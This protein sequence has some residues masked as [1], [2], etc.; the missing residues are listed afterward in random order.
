MKRNERWSPYSVSLFTLGYVQAACWTEEIDHIEDLADSTL[1]RLVADAA[2]FE[3]E[4]R[5]DLNEANETHGRGDASLGHDFWLT[6]NR[7]GAGF[8]DRGMKELGEHLTDAAH[9]YGEDYIE[10]SPRMMEE[11]PEPLL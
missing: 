11:E 7:H 2:A 5:N 6:R 4:Y 10:E 1:A 3:R 9:A 8:W